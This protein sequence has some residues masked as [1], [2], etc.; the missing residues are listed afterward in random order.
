MDLGLQGRTAIV[1]GATRGI[2]RAIADALIAEG[3]A[4]IGS[5]RW[6]RSMD[7]HNERARRDGQTQLEFVAADSMDPRSAD[8]LV[9][10]AIERFGRLD[11]IVN[12]A[13]ALAGPDTDDYRSHLS[14][15]A[16]EKIFAYS[17]LIQQSAPY[18]CGNGVGA[19]VNI[20]GIAGLRPV[21]ET[22]YAAAITAGILS[23]TTFYARTLASSGI[24]V[25]AI[26]PG[27][28][29]TDRRAA[30]V[31]GLR[32]RQ[33]LSNEEADQRLRS[34]IPLGRP[35]GPDEVAAMTVFLLSDRAAAITG[36]NVPID[37]GYL[38]CR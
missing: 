9:A 6:P 19:V 24:R 15:L 4:V 36:I 13:G 21:G 32:E 33:G 12:N 29:D 2:G 22:P 11:L 35:V 26:S 1:T 5:T 23:L 18:I 17:Q 38:A 31:A 8:V 16:D 28:T 34:E 3:A 30:R 27:D 14:H 10:R 20:A 25:N 37:G 7:Q